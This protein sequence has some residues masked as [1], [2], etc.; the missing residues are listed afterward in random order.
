MLS[1][2][3]RYSS[4][5]FRGPQQLQRENEWLQR[6]KEAFRRKVDSV[7]YGEGSVKS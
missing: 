6:E 1:K 7:P 3:F 5:A 2:I 4:V